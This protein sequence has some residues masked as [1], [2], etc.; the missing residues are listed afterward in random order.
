MLTSKW[1]VSLAFVQ[2]LAQDVADSGA[3]MHGHPL[4]CLQ[5]YLFARH[6]LQVPV[7]L[8]SCYDV[9]MVSSAIQELT[10]CC[11]TLKQ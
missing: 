8:T 11:R 4:R 9:L 6:L 7:P 1:I 2:H 3:E 10:S 5:C